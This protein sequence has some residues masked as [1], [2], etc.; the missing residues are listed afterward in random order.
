MREIHTKV[1]QS[2]ILVT[3]ITFHLLVVAVTLMT[4]TSGQRSNK[5]DQ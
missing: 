1:T 4:T 2:C 5:D 3:Q